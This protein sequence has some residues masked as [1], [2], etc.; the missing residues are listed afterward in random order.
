M[1]PNPFLE[2]QL[3]KLV[4]RDVATYY[5]RCDPTRKSPF[6]RYLTH[7]KQAAELVMTSLNKVTTL[8]DS[9]YDRQ[10][11]CMHFWVISSHSISSLFLLVSSI[12]LVQMKYQQSLPVLEAIMLHH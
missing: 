6:T 2:S 10:E 4:S 7:A 3:S 9:H 5:L 11:V 1:D 12:G 8:A